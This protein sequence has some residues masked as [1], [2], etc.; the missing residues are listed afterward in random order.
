[1]A[2]LAAG[3][4]EASKSAS[5]GAT[6]QTEEPSALTAPVDYLGAVGKAKQTAVKT[7]DL[8]SINQAI[9]MFQVEHDRFPRSLEELVQEKY[10]PRIP[11]APYGMKIEYDAQTG[12]V[13]V[14][15][16]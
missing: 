15:K 6:N 2:A 4:S 14:V 1:M 3:C 13:R 16:Q 7:V 12:K 10:L 8:A 9:Q 5:T 11:E